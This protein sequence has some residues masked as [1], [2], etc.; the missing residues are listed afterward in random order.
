MS[1]SLRLKAEDG[2]GLEVLSAALQDSVLRAGDLAYNAK[3]RRFTALVNRFRWESAGAR[4]PF[5]RVR[6]A[7]AVEGVTAVK[8]ARLNRADKGAIAAVLSLAFQPDAEPPGG[9]LSIVL[10]GGGEIR[11]TLECIDAL[12]MDMGAPWPTPRRP[13]H[14]GAA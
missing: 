3:A 10:A 12:L 9:N 13:S 4:G 8:T 5:E 2:P 7:F 1:D 14:E 11:L 6:A